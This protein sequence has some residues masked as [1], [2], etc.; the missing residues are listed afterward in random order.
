MPLTDAQRDQIV[1][2]ARSYLGTEW[3]GQGRDHSGIDCVGLC[4]NA[5][6]EGGVPLARTAATYRGIDSK[7][8]MGVLHRDFERTTLALAKPGDLVVYRLLPT[9][10]AHLVM[11]MPGK[12]FNAI[13]CPA[14][15]KVVEARF[16]PNP[17]RGDIGG[18]YTWR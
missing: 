5:Y 6:I 4:E 16:D 2:A 1:A 8:L 7:L 11:L 17:S 12:P 3:R 13:H 18:F 15:Y 9:R 10:A 14:N